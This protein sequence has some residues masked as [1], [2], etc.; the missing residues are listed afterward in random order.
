MANFIDLTGQKFGRLTVLYKDS[1]RY[2]PK[3]RKL[4]FWKCQ[5]DCGKITSTRGENLKNGSS[6]SCGCL[7]N[8]LTKARNK[9]RIKENRYEKKG[10][11]MIGY[12]NSGVPFYFD[13][14]DYQQVKQYCW[15]QNSQGYIH[16]K[17]REAGRSIKL[18]RLVMGVN[19]PKIYLDH[20]N[21]NK[22]DCRKDN[23]RICTNAQ[24]QINRNLR[25]DNV[26][27]YTGICFNRLKN[28][29]VATISHKEKNIHIGYYHDINDALS[30]RLSK[31][32]EFYGEFSQMSAVNSNYYVS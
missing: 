11:Y 30:A 32:R 14:D 5:C 10:N 6:K 25:K 2:S 26:S 18:H 9:Q 4:I 22:Q 16:A 28:K 7:A 3:G 27:G 1:D 21:R 19:N 15:S 31:E 12:T 13:L 24:N 8:E 20:I 29:W 17:E 23:L